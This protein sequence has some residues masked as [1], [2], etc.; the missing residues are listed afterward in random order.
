MSVSFNFRR[1]VSTFSLMLALPML[2]LAFGPIHSNLLI[3]AGKQFILGGEQRGA[4]TVKG[5]NTGKVAVR[6][7]ERFASGDTLGRGVAAPG[8][9]VALSFQKGSAAVIINNGKVQANLDL[10]ITGDTGLGMRYEG[11]QK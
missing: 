8:A 3:D 11:D 4:F 5:K 7:V 9:R 10:R 6:V 2:A 1:F